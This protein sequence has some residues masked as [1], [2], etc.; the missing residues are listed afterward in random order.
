MRRHGL[1]LIK[2]NG[3]SRVRGSH[4]TGSGIPR[5]SQ[6]PVG[7]SFGRVMTPARLQI[8]PTGVERFFAEDEIIVTKTDVAG[9]ITYANPVFLRM[10]GYREA[11]ALGAPHSLIRHPEMPR[12]VFKLLWDRIMGGH[13]IFAYVNN[14]ASNGDHYWVLAHVTPSHDQHGSLIGFHSMRRVPDRRAVLAVEPLYAAL[15]AEEQRHYDRARGLEASHAMMV[16][17]L[18]KAGVSYDEWVWSL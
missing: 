13:E 18:D 17:I 8:A 3:T 14:M 6:T 10:A 15:L 5:S 7:P 11:E 4:P 1:T 9:R 12:A 16:D 2:G